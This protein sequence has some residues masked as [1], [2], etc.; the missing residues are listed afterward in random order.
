[1]PYALCP[2]VPHLSE[3]GYIWVLE[4]IIAMFFRDR[5]ILPLLGDMLAVVAIAYFIHAFFGSIPNVQK[6]R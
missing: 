5:W 6:H 1:M 4:A 3:K 2:V